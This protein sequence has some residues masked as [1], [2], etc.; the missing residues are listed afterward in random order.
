[1]YGITKKSGE[2]WCAYYHRR[3]N[4]DVRSVRF[5]GLIGYRSPPGG[6][7]TDYAV[8]IYHK[9]L[10]GEKFTCYLK[11]DAYLPMVYT[12]DA[13][14]GTIQLMDAP[15]D[16]IKIRTSYNIGSMSFCPKEIAEAI[17]K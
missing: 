13:I 2:L 5:P 11:E 3:Y 14:N 6:G 17:K 4:V 8:D 9:A 1:M 16:K 10:L 15:R 7:T 12:D